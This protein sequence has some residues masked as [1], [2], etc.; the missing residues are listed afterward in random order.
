MKVSKVKSVTVGE[1][2]TGKYGEMI[3]HNYEM[4]DGQKIQAAHKTANPIKVGETVEYEVK[5]TH[6]VYGDSGSVSKPK[7]PFQGGKRKPITTSYKDVLGMV[8]SNAIHAM[9]VVN[10]AYNQERITSANLPEIEKFT[11]GDIN[12]DLEKFGEQDRLLTSRLAAVN[13]AAIA[14]SYKTFNNASEMLELAK[15]FYQYTTK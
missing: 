1:T 12:G 8:R 7:E 14:S 15:A 6:E 10:S 9:V 4:E 11:I 13:N 5:R 2:Y 3:N